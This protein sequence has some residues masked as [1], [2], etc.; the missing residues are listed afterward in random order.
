[1]AAVCC[2]NGRRA[3]GVAVCACGNAAGKGNRRGYAGG[4]RENIGGKGE[5]GRFAS[6]SC[7]TI[8]SGGVHKVLKKAKSS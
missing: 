5:V 6:W 7:D 8:A 1:M 4:E 2:D 3:K